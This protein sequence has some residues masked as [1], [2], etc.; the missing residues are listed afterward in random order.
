MKRV[1]GLILLTLGVFMLVLGPLLKF[2]VVPRIAASP[3]DTYSTSKLDVIFVKA[4]NVD[5]SLKGMSVVYDENVK[6]SS[7]KVVRGDVNASQQEP[8]KGEGLAVYD[9]FDRV[10]NA[11]GK[12]FNAS[13]ARYA[14]NAKTSELSECCGANIDGKPAKFSGIAPFKMPF[15]LKSGEDIE[16]VYYQTTQTT[17]PMVFQEETELYGMNVYKY[18]QVIP[19]TKQPG[20]ELEVP[21]ELVGLKGSGNV[22]LTAYASAVNRNFVAPV[23]GQI[24]YGESDGKIVARTPKGVEVVTLAETKG[25]SNPAAAEEGAPAIKSLEDQLALANG[26]APWGLI[27]VGALLALLGAMLTKS[28]KNA[29]SGT[30]AGAAPSSAQD[31]QVI[32]PGKPSS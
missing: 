7:I 4:L 10:D 16:N 18:E 30:P 28:A 15:F 24:V 8:A 14:F 1:L 21:R 9:I 13:T 3:L 17:A 19:P 6:G 22:M 31:T 20:L 11:A 12:L 32:D 27:I 26:P 2:V 25:N 23:T 5:K 29:E